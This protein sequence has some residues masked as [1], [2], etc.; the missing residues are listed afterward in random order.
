MHPDQFSMF[1]DLNIQTTKT[2]ID[3]IYSAAVLLPVYPPESQYPKLFLHQ[4]SL[5]LSPSC[6]WTKLVIISFKYF[7]A[8]STVKQSNCSLFICVKS[9]NGA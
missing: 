7:S 1:Q 5:L 6:Y 9:Y 4:E 8:A 3:L 2:Q